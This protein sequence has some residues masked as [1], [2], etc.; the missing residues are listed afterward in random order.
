MRR[1]RRRASRRV[2]WACLAGAG[3]TAILAMVLLRFAAPNAG[4]ALM[5]ADERAIA[6]ER[7]AALAVHRFAANPRILVLDFPGLTEQGLMFNRVAAFA[8]KSGAPRD[9]L[10]SD[11]ELAAAIAAHGDTVGTY[12][13][14]H[15][16]S[17][18]TLA[19]FFA[20][21]DR[22]GVALNAQE[23]RLRALAGAQGMLVANSDQAV[24]TL[25]RLGADPQIDAAFRAAT[26]R[27]ELSHGE[28][29]TVPAYA[30]YVRAFWRDTM[31]ARDRAAFTHFL[32]SQEYD[33]SQPDLTVNE[34]QAYLVHTPD[35]RLISA[36]IVGLPDEVWDAL[37]TKFIAGMPAGWLRD[38]DMAKSPA[39][40]GS[41]LHQ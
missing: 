24:I 31:D 34:M 29:F 23:R 36:R 30:D 8:E 25:P 5:L 41:G 18:A 19:R 40:L 11:A 1:P 28:F 20:V 12:Y 10:L 13:Y 33:A 21:A 9:R 38:S 26:L 4:A 7:P 22:D 35:K 15:D 2:V 3:V 37:R 27:H 17:S 39:S 6:A 32:A 14:G 16:Y